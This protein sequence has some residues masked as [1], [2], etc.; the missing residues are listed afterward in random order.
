MKQT[1][2]LFNIE[3]NF[4]LVNLLNAIQTSC[5]MIQYEINKAALNNNHGAS[6][7]ENSSGDVQ[8]KLDVISNDIMIH[9]L[10]KSKECC[11]LISEE[12]DKPIYVE[13]KYRGKY[14]VTFD[15]L[16]G[17]SNIDCNCVIGTI[18]SIF[19]F[20]N[21]LE[22]LDETDTSVY[23]KK[24]DEM[25]CSGYVLYGPATEL[26]ITYQKN[27]GVH[28]FSLDNSIGEFILTGQITFPTNSKPIYSVNEASYKTWNNATKSYIYQYKEAGYTQRLIGSMVGDVHRTL[29]YGGV[30]MYPGNTTNPNG[31][32]RVLYE[33]FP[34]ARIIEEAGGQAIQENSNRIL[35]IIPKTIH[36][37]TSIL[38]GSTNE[39]DKYIKLLSKS[40]V[41]WN[42]H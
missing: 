21:E 25:V 8:K 30:F 5:N 17:S 41:S 15:P 4:D 37:R 26:V 40:N 36:E 10:T 14:I 39:I 11:V 16:D 33:C 24:G 31:K 23:M 22:N 12:N 38:V 42:Q 6:E 18:F 13:K 32:L 35:D 29:L 20:D 3:N 28:K 19:K 1:F 27:S 9:N 7:T 2:T 34:I